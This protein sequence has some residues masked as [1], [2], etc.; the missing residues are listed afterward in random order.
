[1][2]S[3]WAAKAMFEYAVSPRARSEVKSQNLPS[4]QRASLVMDE[5]VESIGDIS[6]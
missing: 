3:V 6:H 1:V 4:D 2:L 5:T